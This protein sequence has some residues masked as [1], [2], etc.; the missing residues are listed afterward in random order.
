MRL[1][2]AAPGYVLLTLFV[3]W[4][5]SFTT[6]E[7]FSRRLISTNWDPFFVALQLES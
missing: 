4:I 1:Q 2:A 6:V 5:P 3:T 7:H